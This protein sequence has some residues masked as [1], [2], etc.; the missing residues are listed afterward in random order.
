MLPSL[1]TLPLT[2]FSNLVG[3]SRA[4][5]VPLPTTDN[6]IS[7]IV[8]RSPRPQAVANQILDDA[9]NTRVIIHK[10]VLQLIN[11][12]LRIKLQFGSSIEKDLYANLT[13]KQFVQR[14]VSKRPLTFVGPNDSTTGRD[15]QYIPDAARKWR[16]VGMEK[17][18]EPLVLR[19]YLS[20]D[21]IAISALLGVSSPT[22]FINP[23]DRGNE[24]I[25]SKQGTFRERGVYVGVV[26]AR[27]E[28]PDE[29]ESRFLIQS[30]EY[31][32]PQRGYGFYE[33]VTTHDQALLQMWARFYDMKDESTGIYGFPVVHEDPSSAL[34]IDAYKL[35]IRIT[36]ETF[37]FEAENRGQSAGQPVHAFIVGLGLGVWQYDKE[38]QSTAF[39]DEI[40]AIIQRSSFQ[41]VRVV[42]ISWVA[43]QYHGK[44]QL[45]ID[46]TNG[47]VV[48]MVLTRGNPAAKRGEGW[49]LVACYAWDGNAFPGNEVWGGSL[50]ASGDPAAICCSTIG[51]L[52]NPYVNPFTENVCIW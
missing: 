38:A 24:G 6:L 25:L 3:N 22:Y 8:A 16:L 2:G 20:Y 48:T 7:S 39:L 51:E 43:Q 47:D 17:E 41:H 12:F 1:P 28:I 26:G 46:T 40:V 9:K 37:L 34:R 29:M 35:R 27:F 14:L 32:T 5:P 42:E 18:E 19:D 33:R 31:C 13:W 23:G 4:F 11:E 49:L 21:E 15:G 50:S 30:H 45:N 52:Q 44:S 36:L 10:Q